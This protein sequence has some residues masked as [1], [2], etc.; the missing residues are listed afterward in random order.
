MI[1]ADIDNRNTHSVRK[2]LGDFQNEILYKRIISDEF[3][4]D[5]YYMCQVITVLELQ[6]FELHKERCLIVVS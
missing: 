5:L 3:R 1:L 4:N 6:K 2:G